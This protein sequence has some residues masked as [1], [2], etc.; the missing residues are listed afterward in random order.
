MS[1]FEYNLIVSFTH[2]NVIYRGILPLDEFPDIASL[3]K[4]MTVSWFWVEVRTTLN[5]NTWLSHYL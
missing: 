3:L 4:S 1:I 2:Q 5:S